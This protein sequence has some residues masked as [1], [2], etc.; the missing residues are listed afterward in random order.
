M[1]RNECTKDFECLI[2]KLLLEN[3]VAC[4]MGLENNNTASRRIET[5]Q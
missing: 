5:N 4:A 2:L 3:L 1:H